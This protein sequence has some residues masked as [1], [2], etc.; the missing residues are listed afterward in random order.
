MAREVQLR[1]ALQWET[2][3]AQ[4]DDKNV[5][6]WLWEAV[7]GD[8]NDDRSIGQIA[9]DAAI[10]V[11]PVVD[12][13]CDVRD[14]IANCRA[15]ATSDEKEDTTWK[16]VALTLT[17]IG[18]F[19]SLGSVVKGVLKIFFVFVR[20]YGL[21]KLLKAVDDAMTW[22]ITYL[23]KPEVQKLLRQQKVD[24]VFKWLADAVRRVKAMTTTSNLLQAFDRGIS[25]MKRLL[26][27]VTD[28]PLIGKRARATI[29]MVEKIRKLAD[30]QIGKAL[31]PVQK[32]LDAVI[33]RLEMESLVQRS[34]ILDARNVHFRGVLPEARAVTLMKQT[35]PPPAWLSKG[36]A[37]EWAEAQPNIWRPK[38]DAKLKAGYPSLTDGNIKSFHRLE[39]VEIKGPARLYRVVSPTNGAMGDCWIPE[40]VW[41]KIQSA[42]D[43][44]AAWRKYLAVWPDW[45]PNGQFVVMEIPAGESLKVWRGPAASQVKKDHPSLA[46]HLEGGWDQVIFK[47]RPGE[48]D[49]T[50]IYKLG[51]GQGNVLHRTDMSYAQYSTLPQEQKAAFAP[52]RERINHPNIR[53]PLDTGWG[54][55]DFDPQWQH[56]RIGL[57]S[58]A[59]QVTN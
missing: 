14:I 10:S 29:E 5:F 9:F 39:A 20:R 26:G 47:P 55:T 37:V 58:L 1:A 27:K 25:I 11:I 32:I 6:Q 22:V 15:I 54:Y 30:V 2:G 36:K 57:P 8:F 28:L 41:K 18:L 51:G 23:R 59:G 50:R 40:D 7:Q 48:W 46:A 53:G 49:T 24:E 13:I 33:R 4:P 52:M 38:V 17:L 31:A 35:E 19:P 44:K 16:W 43:P 56:G 12:Q 45:N 34:G 42:P 3:A 21:D